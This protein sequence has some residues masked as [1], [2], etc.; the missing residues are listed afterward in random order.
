MLLRFGFTHA[1]NAV[2]L[3]YV[4][5]DTVGIR[6]FTTFLSPAARPYAKIARHYILKAIF[7]VLMP[8]VYL[9]LILAIRMQSYFRIAL[10]LLKQFSIPNY[11]MLNS[12][13]DLFC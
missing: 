3:A 2:L 5:I 6:V 11:V 12:I 13:S 4:A 1:V 8:L 9:V 7:G 10:Q